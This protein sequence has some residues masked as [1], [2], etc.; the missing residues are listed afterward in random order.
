MH[1]HCFYCVFHVELFGGQ[2]AHLPRVV[3]ERI[4]H[5]VYAITYGYT[6]RQLRFILLP[7]LHKLL[8]LLQLERR[9]RIFPSPLEDEPPYALALAHIVVVPGRRHHQE[10][11]KRDERKLWVMFR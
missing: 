11:R 5:N 7:I 8:I 6:R 2:P 3:P 10:H 4:I 9:I 1:L